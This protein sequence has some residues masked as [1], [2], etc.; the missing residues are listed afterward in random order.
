MVEL[1]PPALGAP[2]TAPVGIEAGALPLMELIALMVGAL[3]EE[4]L[5]D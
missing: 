4:P 5:I 3:I 1:E 2:P